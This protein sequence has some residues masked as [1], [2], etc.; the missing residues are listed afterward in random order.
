[1]AKQV[2]LSDGTLF[3]VRSGPTFSA[4]GRRYFGSN[5]RE[6]RR[7]TDD[8]IDDIN[9]RKEKQMDLEYHIIW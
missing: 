6:A 5:R 2:K 3:T 4:A 7:L 9:L 8:M 1:M